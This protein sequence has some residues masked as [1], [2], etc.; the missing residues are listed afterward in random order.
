MDLENVREKGPLALV[1][2]G[3]CKSA[4]DSVSGQAREGGKDRGG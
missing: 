4:V 3:N 1:V 2:G